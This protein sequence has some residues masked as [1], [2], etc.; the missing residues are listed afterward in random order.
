MKRAFKSLKILASVFLLLFLG[1]CNKDRQ[2]ADLLEVK[3]IIG[4]HGATMKEM[5]KKMKPFE[6]FDKGNGAY[7]FARK[8]NSM[9]QIGNFQDISLTV[10]FN[11]SKIDHIHLT[12]MEATRSFFDNEV[13]RLY[14]DSTFQVFQERHTWHIEDKHLHIFPIENGKGVMFEIVNDQVQLIR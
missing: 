7:T 4:L 5:Q 12:S 13:A 10:Y 8:K 9:L 3:D 11:T 14:P 1:S 2:P 6:I